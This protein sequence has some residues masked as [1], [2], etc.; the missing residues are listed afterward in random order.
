MFSSASKQKLYYQVKFMQDGF[1]KRVL[2]Y[3]GT[4]YT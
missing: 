1:L 2:Q 3:F 4:L